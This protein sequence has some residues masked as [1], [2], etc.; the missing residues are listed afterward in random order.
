MRHPSLS[1]VG[2]E[3]GHVESAARNKMKGDAGN[4]PGRGG[5]GTPIQEL[6][7]ILVAE[8]REYAGAIKSDRICMIRP[9]RE[10]S[11]PCRARGHLDIYRKKA[12]TG[13]PRGRSNGES[14]RRSATTTK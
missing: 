1:Y 11:R 13:V 4:T 2:E 5:M 10:C 14:V 8:V 9:L 3:S 12:T 7:A 6:S